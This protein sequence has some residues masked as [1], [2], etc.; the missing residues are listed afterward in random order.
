[1]MRDFLYQ[2]VMPLID[3]PN[4]EESLTGISTSLKILTLSEIG[5][6]EETVR[7]HLAARILK[8]KA[9]DSLYREM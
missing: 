9:F 8:V 3:S 1:M 6:T 5:K 4:T 7:R 2:D